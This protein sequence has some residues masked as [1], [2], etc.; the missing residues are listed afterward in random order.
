MKHLHMKVTIKGA[1]TPEQLMY[2]DR[3]LHVKVNEFLLSLPVQT[4]SLPRKVREL[5]VVG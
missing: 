3:E 1:V 5:E 2:L 4:P